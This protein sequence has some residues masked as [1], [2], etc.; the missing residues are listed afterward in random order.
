MVRE[1]FS[2]ARKKSPC[3]IFIDEIDAI[4]SKRLDSSTSGDREVQ[5]TL[6]Q[7]LS[8]LDGF[9]SLENVKVI[10]ATN[11]PELL[12]KALLR[13]GRFDR[14]VEI[15]LPTIEGREAI[16]NVHARKMPL[17]KSVDFSKLAIMTEGYSGAEIKAITIEVGMKAISEEVSKCKMTHFKEAISS[18][19]TKRKG[20]KNNSPDR[21]YG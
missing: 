4:G 18:I 7:L 14:I 5:R 2:L 9:D 16:F 3:I 1:L 19:D 10:A 12:D 17:D 20:V 21:L 11:R 8:E 13:P 15:P 6:M